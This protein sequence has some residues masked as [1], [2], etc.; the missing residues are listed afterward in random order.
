MLAGEPPFIGPSLGVTA[1]HLV[2]PPPSLVTKRP[3]LPPGLENIVFK[4]LAKLPAD[5]YSTADQF[6]DAL[7]AIQPSREASRPAT[8]KLLTAIVV[9]LALIVAGLILTRPRAS[10]GPRAGRWALPRHSVQPSRRC[11]AAAA[12]RRPVR[13]PSP[14]GAEPL[15]RSANRGSALGGRPKAET[16]QSAFDV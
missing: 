7:A 14:R 15:G 12:H 16:A 9:V 10:S 5:R 8:R 4:A 6:S 1:G 11:R 3:S 2:D 13:N